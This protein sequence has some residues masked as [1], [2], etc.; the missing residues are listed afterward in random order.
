M[1]KGKN[2]LKVTGILMIIFGAIALIFG[3]IAL[4]G[5]LALDAKGLLLIAVILGLVSAVCEIIAGIVGVK[6][7]NK[8]EK[9]GA[10]IAW[11]VITLILALAGV[12][13]SILMGGSSVSSII[14]SIVSS[15]AIPVLYL[16]G[17]GLNKKSA[18]MPAEE[19]AVEVPA[20]EPKQSEIE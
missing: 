17:A 8:P 13:I 1:N 4:L 16:I 11:G 18:G 14:V 7:C 20:E 15:I 19:S 6:N 12:V 2:F 3:I 10:C 5:V 9:A